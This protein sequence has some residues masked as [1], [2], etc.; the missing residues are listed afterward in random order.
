MFAIT[1]NMMSMGEYAP[2]RQ[3][4]CRRHYRG[5]NHLPASTQWSS[6]PV[7]PLDPPYWDD[8]LGS[9][10]RVGLAA[11]RK[12][13]KPALFVWALM[14]GIALLY[15]LVPASSGIF[16]ALV[17]VQEQMGV[18]FPSVGMGLS[19]GIMVEVVRV[20]TS[21][22]KRWTRDNSISALFNFAI[23]SVMGV[24]QYFRYA[25]QVEVFGDGNSFS[26]VASKVAFDQFVWT[27]IFAN[28]YQAILYLWKNCNYSWRAVA[29]LAT[30]LRTFWGTR[31]L[32]M[33]I[34]NWAFWIPMAGL[35]YYFPPELQVPMAIL[36]VTIWV[37]L[38][39]FLT[40][41]SRHED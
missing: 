38:I 21:P 1:D 39:S 29:R 3:S 9:S 14:T 30:P 32:P 28:P 7:L 37:I 2:I 34:S 26:E 12:S 5:R 10:V 18:W 20:L 6:N 31:M 35:V 27:V 8:M 25:W 23:W 19:V 41:T 16:S 24:T 33:L 4:E 11:A 15:Y 22:D 36:A 13:L 40:A 17:E